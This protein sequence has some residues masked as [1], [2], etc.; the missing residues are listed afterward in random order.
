MASCKTV[1]VANSDGSIPNKSTR[2]LINK[3]E[4]TSNDFQFFDGKAKIRYVDMA[5]NQSAKISI[6]IKKGEMI[7]MSAT[8]FGIEGMRAK[9]TPDSVHVLNRLKKEYIV[10]PLSYIKEQFKLPADYSTVE[11]MLVGNPV[12]LE[13]SEFSVEV[14]EGQYRLN[15]KNPVDA[16][17]VINGRSYQLEELVLQDASNQKV[18]MAFKEYET[19]ED[20]RSFSY[21]RDILMTS[22]SKGNASVEL[23]FTKATFDVEK[24]MSFKVPSSYKRI[25]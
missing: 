4:S 6:R 18:N 3:M 8:L 15:T 2:F 9:I 17:Y 25:N 12:V 19:M 16:T 24:K 5:Q 10:K 22:A 11:A 20:K 21:F 14:K 7:W 1:Q 23:N 13:G